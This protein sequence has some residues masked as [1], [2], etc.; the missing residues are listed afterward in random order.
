[1]NL[2]RT[3]EVTTEIS[4]PP[5]IEASAYLNTLNWEGKMPS[6]GKGGKEEFQLLNLQ[7]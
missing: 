3:C 2:G 7:V 4:T 5:F 6:Q 1:M